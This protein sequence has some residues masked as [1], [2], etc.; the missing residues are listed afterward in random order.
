MDVECACLGSEADGMHGGV[1][2]QDSIS[3]ASERAGLPE[4]HMHQANNHLDLA[5]AFLFGSRHY[6]AEVGDED[7][8]NIF[9][10]PQ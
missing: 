8:C 5:W 2:L 7:K 6:A 9:S 1:S 10:G 3:T 4:F